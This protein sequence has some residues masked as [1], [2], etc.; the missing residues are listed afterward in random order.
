MFQKKHLQKNELSLFGGGR[1]KKFL[2]FSSFQNDEKQKKGGGGKCH[3]SSLKC[4]SFDHISTQ[5][6]DRLEIFLYFVFA[7]VQLWFFGVLMYRAG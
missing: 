3:I 1:V 5:I 4:T 6:M 2:K 7:L